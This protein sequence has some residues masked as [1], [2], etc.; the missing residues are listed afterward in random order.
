MLIRQEAKTCLVWFFS[1]VE[2]LLRETEVIRYLNSGSIYLA[3][4]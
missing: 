2:Y 3:R 1:K 4:S